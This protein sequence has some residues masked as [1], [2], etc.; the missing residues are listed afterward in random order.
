LNVFGLILKGNP[1]GV[2]VGVSWGWGAGC[3]DNTLGNTRAIPYSPYIA[4]VG[5]RLDISSVIRPFGVAASYYK[6]TS[7]R[8]KRGALACL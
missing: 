3:S 5:R 8:H 2:G 1:C 7:K 6:V 4:P